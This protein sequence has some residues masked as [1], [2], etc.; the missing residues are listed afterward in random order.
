MSTAPIPS[1]DYAQRFLDVRPDGSWGFRSTPRERY[2]DKLGYPV[3]SGRDLE[4]W[5]AERNRFESR[6]LHSMSEA[7]RDLVLAQLKNHMENNQ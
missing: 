4:N 7:D 2:S 6:F 3:V 1:V 5:E